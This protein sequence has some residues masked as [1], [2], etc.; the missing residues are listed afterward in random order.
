VWKQLNNLVKEIFQFLIITTMSY[1]TFACNT[2]FLVSAVNKAARS[3]LSKSRFST[4][5]TRAYPEYRVYGENCLLSLKPIFATFK[6]VGKNNGLAVDKVGRLML[7]FVPRQTGNASAFAYNDRMAVA[8]SAEEVGLILNQLP[9][10]SVRIFRK[11]LNND[12]NQEPDKVLSVT[13]STGSS[14]TF[15]LNMLEEDGRDSEQFSSG[16]QMYEVNVQAG[17]Y[18]IIKNLCQQSLTHLV[19]WD[20]LVKVETNRALANA[21]EDADLLSQSNPFS[22]IR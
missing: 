16:N 12:Y 14:V 7:D 20:T 22:Q 19:G 15:Q 13:P 6:P 17:E 3:R 4:L 5:D 1:H 18:E 21:L 2:K 9:E 8:L 11:G 10:L